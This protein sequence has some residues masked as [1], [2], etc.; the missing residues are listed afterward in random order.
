MARALLRFS[1]NNDVSSTT[2]N[3]I[4]KDLELA[5][6][7]KRG[8]GTWEHDNGVGG[9]VQPLLDAVRDALKGSPEQ[10]GSFG[11]FD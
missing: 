7:V 9:P 3:E 2:R 4:V 1:L 8:T 6:F 10:S 5:G 11:R